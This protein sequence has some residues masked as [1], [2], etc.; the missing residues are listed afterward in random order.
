M[1]DTTTLVNPSAPAGKSARYAKPELERRF[2]AA[3]VPGGAVDK[4]AYIVDRYLVGTRL[5]LRQMIETRGAV[6]STYCKFTQKVP[7]PDGGPGLISTTYLNP[8]EYELLATL[9]AAI[10]RKTR[11]SVPPFGIDEYEAP[12]AGLYVAEVEF[13]DDA[14][15]RAFSPPPWVIAEVT[16]DSRFTGGH[17]AKMQPEDLTVLLSAFGL[18]PPDSR[19][20]FDGSHHER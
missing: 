17:F 11:Y 18:R 20:V 1:H 4:T 7:A 16:L 15:M 13:D 5:R 2:L 3:G 9:P 19:Q 14:A 8:D 12:L 10:L 6:T